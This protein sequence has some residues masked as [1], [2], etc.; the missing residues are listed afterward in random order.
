MLEYLVIHFANARRKS[1]IMANAYWGQWKKRK[2]ILVN[3][4]GNYYK[5]A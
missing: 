1:P 3:K 4:N 2:K 5:S